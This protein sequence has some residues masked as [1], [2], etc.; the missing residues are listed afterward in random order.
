MTCVAQMNCSMS[1]LAELGLPIELMMLMLVSL[2]ELK[3]Y[4]ARQLYH[5]S[6]IDCG[7]ETSIKSFIKRGI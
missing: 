3:Q 2:D 1:V 7:Q 5:P 4:K 6:V